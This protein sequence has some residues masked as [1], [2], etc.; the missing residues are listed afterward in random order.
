MLNCLA[1][2]LTRALQ[3]WAPR[4]CAAA[5]LAG[6]PLLC[7]ELSAQSGA[8]SIQGTVTDPTGAVLP[9]ATIHVISQGTNVTTDTKSN[10]V[11]FYQVPGLFTGSYTLT[12]SAPGM[13]TFKVTVQL[14]VAQQAIVNPVMT[15]GDVT[16]QVEVSADVVQLTD[17]ESGTITSTLDSSRLDQIPMNGRT[18]VSL[19][20]ATTPGLE[21]GTRANG[22]MDAGL[23]YVADGVPLTNRNFGGEGNSTQA[24]LPDPDS[25]KAVKIETINTSAMYS[26]PSTAIITTKSGTNLLHGSL[27]ETSRNNALGIAKTRSDPYNM[28]APHL[29]RNEFGASVGGP[30][31]N[32]NKHWNP[33][34]PYDGRGKSFWFFA[35]ERYSLSQST[36][37]NVRVPMAAWRKGDFSGLISSSNVLQQLYDPSSTYSTTSCAYG[38]AKVNTACRT[39]FTN[40]QIPYASIS[41]AAKILYDI[42]PAPTTSD[43]PLVTTNET[44][45]NPGFTV[46]PT[47]T[48]RIDQFFNAKNTAYLRYTSN[49]Q[50]NQTLRNYPSNYAGTLNSAI[51]GLPARAEGYSQTLISNFGAAL[52]FTHIFSPTFFSETILSQNWFMQY[53]GGCCGQNANIESTLGLPNNFGELGFPYIS[54]LVMPYGGTMLQYQ[55]NQII[56]QID[57]NLTK[58]VGKHQMQFGGR[59]RHERFAYLPDRLADTIAFTAQATGLNSVVT[60]TTYGQLA[61]TGYYDADFYLGAANSYSVTQEPPNVH[62]HDMEFDGYYQDNWHATKKLTLNLGLRYEAHPAAWTKDGLTTGFDLVNKAIILDN[63]TSWYVS[64]GYTTSAIINN[65]A[66]IGTVFETPRQAGYPTAMIRSYLLTGSPRLGVAYQLS[67]R[68]GTVIR[69]AY[70]RYAFPVPIRNSIR[71]TTTGLPFVASYSQNF[72]LASQSPDGTTNYLLRKPIPTVMGQ[73]TGSQSDTS[74]VNSASANAILPGIALFALDRSYPPNYVT[75][76]NVTIEQPMKGGSAL[77]VS[78]AYTHA[79]NLDHY[80]YFNNHPTQFVYEM[81][82]GVIP[83]AGGASVIGTSAQNTY[84]ATATGPYDQSLYSGSIL[85]DLR[86]GWSNYNALQV[87]Y[88]KLFSKGFAYQIFW[89]WGKPFR[90]G[91]NYFRDGVTY[92][93]QNYLGAQAEVGSFTSTYPVTTAATPPTRPAGVASYMSY[94]ALNHWEG[95]QIDTAIP[96]NRINFN[97][98]YDLPFGKGKKFLGRANRLTDELVGGWQLAGNGRV[99]SQDFAVA[100]SHWGPNNP[101]TVYK[102]KAPIS[103]CRSGTCHPAYEWFNGYIAPSALPGTAATCGSSTSTVVNGLPS[104]WAP[105]QSPVDTACP[106]DSNYGTDQVTVKLTSASPQVQSYG[107]GSAGANLYSRTI[108]DGPINWSADLSAFKVFPIMHRTSLRMNIDVFNAFNVMGYTNPDS[109]TGIEQIQ[110]GVSV[111]SSYNSPRVIQISL[112]LNF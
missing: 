34:K 86:D 65:M 28:V 1:K 112:R 88:Q 66:N 69:G 91:G 107:S 31:Y 77:R 105:Y 32:P 52:G 87:N 80:Y 43:N 94:H 99:V 25:I 97:G 72:S 71:N 15:P 49:N 67:P 96:K 90:M 83:P 70:G 78:W 84:A 108:L 26:E 27:F 89:V 40:N 39:P 16:Q 36:T 62:Y 42:T 104:S 103:D 56:S 68:H 24:Q 101:I 63:P 93:T 50:F 8:G 33:L 53:I 48:F 11:G 3:H 55:E 74:I 92:P 17:S 2:Y 37:E 95:Y 12:A 110:P 79:S 57:E 59:Y 102:H 100:S 47:I 4:L 13:K 30:I 46:I 44:A 23:E 20:G 5:L 76:A 75:Q 51:D 18:L 19:V 14:Q 81:N 41:P 109:T 58:I 10:E 35:Y 7:P 45:V 73:T 54:N 29:V 38:T 98:I 82:T 85:K 60:G 61:N 106:K 6:L 21:G 9:A 22:L 111:A 64:K